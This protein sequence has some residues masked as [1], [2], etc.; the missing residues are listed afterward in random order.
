MHAETRRRRR[1]EVAPAAQPPPQIPKSTRGPLPKVWPADAG[2]DR[3]WRKAVAAAVVASS[4]RWQR[5]VRRVSLSLRGVYIAPRLLVPP[6]LPSYFYFHC[7]RR[8]PYCCCHVSAAAAGL[9]RVSFAP[10]CRCDSFALSLRCCYDGL[11]LVWLPIDPRICFVHQELKPR[12]G[13]PPF[14]GELMWIPHS[15]PF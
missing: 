8:C 3:S 5:P 9:I 14:I 7:R 2:A 10:P 12:G 1:R 13:C 15:V 11:R 6:W 4:L